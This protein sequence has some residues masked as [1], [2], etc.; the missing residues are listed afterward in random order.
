MRRNSTSLLVIA[1]ASLTVSGCSALPIKDRTLYGDKGK[2]GSTAVHTIKKSIPPKAIPKAEWDAMRIGMVCGDA[3][4][5]EELLLLID[6]LCVKLKG[7]CEYEADA[8]AKTK[9]ALKRVAAAAKL[10]RSRDFFVEQ[11]LRARGCFVEVLDERDF[12][13]AHE[14]APIEE[15]F[16]NDEFE[17]PRLQPHP[18]EFTN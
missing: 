16:V 13:V 11:D 1:L 6:K 12:E 9:N 8:V 15:V 10:N 18:L 14:V 7:Q 3:S 4:A 17:A 2:F 5:I